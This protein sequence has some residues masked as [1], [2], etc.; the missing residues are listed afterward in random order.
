[1]ETKTKTQ[2]NDEPERQTTKIKVSGVIVGSEC[3]LDGLEPFIQKGCFTPLSRFAKALEEANGGDVEIWLN[4]PGGDVTAGNEMLALLQSYPGKKTLVL[5]GFVGSMAANIALLSGARV[6]A[7]EQT[8]LMFHSARAVVDGGAGALRDEAAAIER[9]NGPLME[10]LKALGVPPE[11][12]DEGFADGRE[13][14]MSAQEAL[15]F[16]IV[17]KIVKG[18][19]P[20]QQKLSPEEME[21]IRQMNDLHLAALVDLSG[22]AEKPPEPECAPAQAPVTAE[23][24]A[25]GEAPAEDAPPPENAKTDAPAEPSV[26]E[27]LRTAL[28]E[29]DKLA[30]DIRTIQSAAAKKCN[31]VAQAAQKTISEE[32]EKLRSLQTTFDA[33][34][35][36][37]EKTIGEL[38]ARLADLSAK[39][40]ASVNAHAELVG[41]VLT[42]DPENEVMALKDVNAMLDKLPTAKARADW[43]RSHRVSIEAAAKREAMAAGQKGGA[44]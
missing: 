15:T 6:H 17:D 20:V 34:K 29:R 12:V 31:E 8:L 36:E 39:L 23:T 5:G 4:S 21:R 32:Q 22:M 44:R 1:M 19:T 16:H 35:A 27:Q 42:P 7:H 28:A 24:P 2:T 10:R 18:S 26:E 30:S 3:D 13:L 38:E 43:V 14:V 25:E 11:R 40:S 37:K 33:F 41:H 9:I